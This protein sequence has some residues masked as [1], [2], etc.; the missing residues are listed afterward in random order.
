MQGSISQKVT[1]VCLVVGALC[2]SCDGHGRQ[3]MRGGFATDNNRAFHL[4][5]YMHEFH[6]CVN[7]TLDR[8]LTSSV[9][10]DSYLSCKSSVPIWRPLG[11]IP[12][13]LLDQTSDYSLLVCVGAR[14]SAG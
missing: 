2:D 13:G 9:I 10:P 5:D 8:L 4:T 3:G 14:L 12:P 11:V 7:S 6:C 1:E